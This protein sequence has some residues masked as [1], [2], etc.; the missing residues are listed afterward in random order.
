MAVAVVV[1]A[2]VDAEGDAVG[3]AVVVVVVAAASPAPVSRGRERC[4]RT[5]LRV[6]SRGPFIVKVVKHGMSV[7][8]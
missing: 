3:D 8:C 2:A 1:A 4:W 7:I 6:V 5:Y